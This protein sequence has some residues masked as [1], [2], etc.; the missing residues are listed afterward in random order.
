MTPRRFKI[1]N[2]DDASLERLR[3]MEESMDAVI[4]AFEPYHP[5]AN[6]NEDQL[7]RL[8]AIEEEL[9]VVLVAFQKE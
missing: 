9:G 7:Q 5:L 6:L 8:H 1:A 4:L 2:L 3:K